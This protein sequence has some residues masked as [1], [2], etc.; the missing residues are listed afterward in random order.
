MWSNSAYAKPRRHV[1]QV[2]KGVCFHL[3]HDI[4]AI[5][6]YRNFTDTPHLFL[7]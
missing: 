1:Y 2:R 6:L 4:A 3:P 5:C 7:D